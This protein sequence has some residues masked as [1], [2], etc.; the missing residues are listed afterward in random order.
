MI[1]IAALNGEIIQIILQ[2]LGYGFLAGLAFY[3]LPM[4]IRLAVSLVRT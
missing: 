2:A 4:G 1:D 3:F